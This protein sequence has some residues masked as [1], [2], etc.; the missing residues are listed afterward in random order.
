LVISLDNGCSL[1]RITSD[2]RVSETVPAI[3]E[4]AVRKSS[5]NTRTTPSVT[6]KGYPV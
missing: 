6:H 1:S 3:A 2:A 5:T 4:G